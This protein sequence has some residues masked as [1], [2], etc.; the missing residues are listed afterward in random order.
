[1]HRKD[2]KVKNL[3]IGGTDVGLG[4]RWRVLHRKD[5]KVKNKTI[6]GT[7]VQL[8]LQWK[9]LQFRNRKA[10]NQIIGGTDVGL[11]LQLRVLRRKDRKAKSQTIGGTDAQLGPQLR[12]RLVK[13][14]K[15]KRTCLTGGI[16]LRQGP[17]YGLYLPVGRRLR[18]AL[19]YR[20]NRK[21][22]LHCPKLHSL[23][24]GGIGIRRRL[25]HEHPSQLSTGTAKSILTVIRQILLP[26][27]KQVRPQTPL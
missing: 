10:K 19:T 13:T 14:R 6:G 23:L 20:T 16:E 15:A 27:R 7:D 5:R 9:I 25:L 18:K 22:R 17:L 8:G 11:G 4:L 12:V 26:P 2:R 1:L 24:L 21:Q 3:S